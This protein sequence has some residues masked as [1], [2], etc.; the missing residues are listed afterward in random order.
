MSIIESIAEQR[1]RAA[2]EN[3]DFQNLA[4]EGKPLCWPEDDLAPEDQRLAYHLLRQNG[5]S[6]PWI[7]DGIKIRQEIS[8]FQQSLLRVLDQPPYRQAE[9]DPIKE[10]LKRLNQRIIDYNR[11]VPLERLQLP[12]LNFNRE[13]ERTKKGHPTSHSGW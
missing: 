8:R 10:D 2:I 11:I 1:I 5:F 9:L 12:V 4:G 13:L 6:L 3:G 7:E